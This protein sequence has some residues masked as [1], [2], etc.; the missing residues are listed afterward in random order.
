MTALTQN[1]N[2]ANPI[3]WCSTGD[4]ALDYLYRRAVYANVQTE[5]PCLILLDLNLPGTKGPEVLAQI[6]GDETLASIPVI[7]MSSSRDSKDINTCYRNGANSYVI[8]PVGMDD[9]F[10]TVACLRDYWLKIVVLPEATT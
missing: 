10:K 7:I 9:F 2:L 6:K 8:K 4:R 3:V 5:R 1:H